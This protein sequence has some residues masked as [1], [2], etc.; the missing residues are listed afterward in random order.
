MFDINFQNPSFLSQIL[1][2]MRAEPFWFRFFNLTTYSVIFYFLYRERNKSHFMA[3][4]MDQSG[5]QHFAEALMS[6]TK[7]VGGQSIWGTGNIESGSSVIQTTYS[8]FKTLVENG[9][10]VP[11]ALYMIT[12]YQAVPNATYTKKDPMIT[13]VADTYLIIQALTQNTYDENASLVEVQ[14]TG[15]DPDIGVYEVKYTLENKRFIDQDN[16]RGTIT[17]MRDVASGNAAPWDWRWGNGIVSKNATGTTFTD[18][19][20]CVIARGGNSNTIQ[21]ITLGTCT[22]CNIGPNSSNIDLQN[23]DDVNIK[24]NASNIFLHYAYGCNIEYGC[25]GIYMED[26]ANSCL[27]VNIENNS[28]DIYLIN[29]SDCN[30]GCGCSN[31]HIGNNSGF[32]VQYMNI[33]DYCSYILVSPTAGDAQGNVIGD[34]CQYIQF[35]GSNIT[36]GNNCSCIYLSYSIGSA[37][38]SSYNVTVGNNCNYIGLNSTFSDF[39]SLKTNHMHFDYCSIGD[40]CSNILLSSITSGI[41]TFSYCNFQNI[42]DFRITPS[43]TTT[44]ITYKMFKHINNSKAYPLDISANTPTNWKSLHGDISY[45]SA[46]RKFA[47]RGTIGSVWTNIQ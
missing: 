2:E 38:Q 46:T 33:G 23:C 30:I 32:M 26:D 43:T 34:N 16:G 40:N 10:L 39:D 14:Q 9:E 7:T 12:D 13:V 5:A 3:K 35:E 41:C 45:D 8:A 24:N 19:T 44:N 21:N 6:A 29:V 22:D 47:F 28:S 11:G 42:T 20:N 31:I 27:R 1:L 4:Y 25:T 36:I 18:C 37:A 17:Y 15:V